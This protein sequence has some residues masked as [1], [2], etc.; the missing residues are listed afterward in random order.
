MNHDALTT[1]IER[2]H[3]TF[4]PLTTELVAEVRAQLEQLAQAKSSEPW[5][6]ALHEEAPASKELH[7]DGTH[8]FLLLAH[9]E[10]TGLY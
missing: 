1:F 3:A 9:C 7:R 6:A 4:G 8:G 2:A 10:P 5:L